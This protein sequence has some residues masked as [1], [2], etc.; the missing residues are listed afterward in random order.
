M[1]EIPFGRPRQ[2]GIACLLA[3]WCALGI[4]VDLAGASFDEVHALFGDLHGAA[5]LAAEVLCSLPARDEALYTLFVAVL[6][7]RP[8]C[9]LFGARGA[10]LRRA[11]GAA[12]WVIGG[13][14]AAALLFGRSF[15]EVGSAA[16][17]TGGISAGIRSALFFSAWLLLARGGICMLFAWLDAARSGAIE[18]RGAT[19]EVG[20]AATEGGLGVADIAAASHE[21]DAEAA[22]ST[23]RSIFGGRLARIVART[24]SLFDRHPFAAPAIMLAIAWLPVLIGYA[25]ALFMWDTNTQI[26]QWFGLPN[27]ISA[28]VELVDPA[29]LLTQHHPPLHTAMVGLCVQAGMALFGSENAGIFLY[30]LLQW[31]LDI[32]AIAWALRLLVL[33]GADPRVRLAA[34]AFIALVPAF[35]DYSVL[36]TKDV[37]FA[38]ALLVF[39]MEL[40]Y[41]VWRVRPRTGLS[42]LA[43]GEDALPALANRLRPAYPAHPSCHVTALLLSALGTAL[44]RSGMLV[45][46]ALACLVTLVLVRKHSGTRRYPAV[47]LMVAVFVSC[48]LSGIVYPALGISPASKREVLSIPVQQISRFMRERPELVT[49]VEFHAVDAVFDANELAAIYNPDKSDPVKATYREGA[50]SEDLARFWRVWARWFAEDPGCFLSATAANYYGYFYAGQATGWSYTSYFSGVVMAST[51]TDWFSSAVAPYFDFAPAANPISRALDAMCSGYRLFFQRFPLTTLTMQAALY[52]W[53]LV[54]V[55]VYAVTRRVRPLAPMLAAA[56]VVLAV[57][58]VGPCN[59]TTYFRYAYP[60]ALMAP[61]MCALLFARSDKEAFD[62]YAYD[63]AIAGKAGGGAAREAGATAPAGTAALAGASAT[64]RADAAV[65]ADASTRERPASAAPSV[66]SVDG[67]RVAVLIPCYNEAITIGKVVDDFHRVLPDAAIYVYD[68]NSSDD[69]ARIAR[70]HGAT[71]RFEPRQGKGVTVRQMLRDIDAD[72][73]LL[74]DGDDTYPAEAAP[75]LVALVLADEADMTVGDRLSNGSYAHENGRAFHGFGNDLVRWL[76]RAIYGYAFHDVMSG[77]RAFSRVFARTFPV[78]SRGFQLECEVSIHAV[79]MGWRIAEVPIAY[80]DRPEGSSSKLSTVSDGLRV[81]MAIGAL[82]KDCRP[83]K[84][85]AL[86]ASVFLLFGLAVGMPVVAEFSA[87]GFV[88]KLP[89]AVLAVGL[90]F[91]GALS[92]CTGLILDTVAKNRRK[93]WELEVYRIE[94]EARRSG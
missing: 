43:A 44:L 93:Q 33:M 1:S 86:V 74:V 90:V 7:Y 64:G 54:L 31:T 10:R 60:V 94:D 2:R 62:M 83:F 4:G 46:V 32:T 14:F 69:T 47:A 55:T 15:D 57:A 70:E 61:F 45:A 6:L 49:S 19:A 35:S 92:L 48:A 58:L 41:I 91:C 77:Y 72:C 53:M 71:V 65:L 76:I 27:H 8:F 66:R 18:G 82:F 40:V 9:G 67:S 59:A 21:S 56:W 38:A 26:L 89:S 39:A 87:T 36:V 25:P 37:L 42:K 28:S 84:F 73:Y 29:V 81:L 5:Y 17:V 80:R 34:L 88:S 23:G 68:N 51:T 50:T 13:L 11:G 20:A 3:A 85:F 30:A 12:A 78:V 79:D 63:H 22:S 52:D 16:Y 24:C 75:A